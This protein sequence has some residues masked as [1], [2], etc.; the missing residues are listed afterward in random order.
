MRKGQRLGV[1][2]EKR[3][4]FV[5]LAL[6]YLYPNEIVLPDLREARVF[7]EELVH[8]N[9]PAAPLAADIENDVFAVF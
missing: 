7:K 1:W 8:V 6:I 3:F 5:F 2:S 4:V 9:A